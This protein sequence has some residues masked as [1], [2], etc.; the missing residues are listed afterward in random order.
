M[1]L[2]SRSNGGAFGYDASGDIDFNAGKFDLLSENNPVD[3]ISN[4]CPCCRD[5]LHETAV[6]KI[7]GLDDGLNWM[8]L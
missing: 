6:P 3:G 8:R 7:E 4:L 5:N 2:V 1:I